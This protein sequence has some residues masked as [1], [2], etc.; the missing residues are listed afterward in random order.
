MKSHRL[1]AAACLVALSLALLPT[2]IWAVN[3]VNVTGT[4]AGTDGAPSNGV[5]PDASGFIEGNAG[6]S[7]FTAPPPADDGNTTYAV[8]ANITGGNGGATTGSKPNLN[9][10]GGAGA[11]ALLVQTGS[12]VNPLVTVNGGTYTGGSG[13]N[14]GGVGTEISGGRGG[15][16][17]HVINTGTIIN[18]GVFTGGATGTGQNSSA[19][20]FGG[21]GLFASTNG[22]QLGAVTINDGTFQGGSASPGGLA[23]D[24]LLVIDLNVAIHGGTFTGGGANAFGINI[25]GGSITLYGSNFEVNGVSTTGSVD[26]TGT[27]TGTLENVSSPTSITFRTSFTD[28]LFLV[29]VPEPNSAAILL[30]AAGLLGLSRKRRMA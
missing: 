25:D 29:D 22:P 15:D 3:T 27:I 14:A 11:P 24:G 20:E 10:A 8:N 16:G 13:G 19:I 21:N 30:G 5:T 28:T 26:G 9:Y 18:G 1:A 17:V 4:I 7:G 6:S 23:G 2:Q 12:S